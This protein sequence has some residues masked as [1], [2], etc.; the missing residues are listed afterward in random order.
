MKTETILATVEFTIEYSN[1]DA[2]EQAIEAI[3][4]YQD[5]TTWGSRGNFRVKAERVIN[6]VST[7]GEG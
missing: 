2:R 1:S 6:C 5:S 4:P 3:K 7:G